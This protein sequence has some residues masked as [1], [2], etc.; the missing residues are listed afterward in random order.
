MLETLGS[1][2]RAARKAQKMT[3]EELADR[4]EAARPSISYWENGKVKPDS[5]SLRKLS[6]VLKVPLS[7]LFSENDNSVD[8][9]ESNSPDT[10]N[11][12]SAIQNAH[13]ILNTSPV[14]GTEVFATLG[15]L[16]GQLH[17]S[18]PDMVPADQK[19]VR[20]M[21]IRCL[22][23]T[24]GDKWVDDFLGITSENVV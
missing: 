8:T 21:L 5:E 9:Y 24:H 16:I 23:L 4:I 12:K 18:Y 1:K 13:T 20:E 22:R 10:K 14:P 2:I 15:L 11:I 17:N 6:E 3:Q 7:Y 19:L